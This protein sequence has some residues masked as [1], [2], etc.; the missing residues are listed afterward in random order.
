[1]IVGLAKNDSRIKVYIDQVLNGEFLVENNQSGTASFAYQPF[2]PLSGGNHLVYTEAVDSR[3]KVSSWSN[4]VYFQVSGLIEPTISDQAAIEKSDTVGEI[5]EDTS[6]E[7]LAVTITPIEGTVEEVD[8]L[9]EELNDEEASPVEEEM[10]EAEPTREED[11]VNELIARVGEGEPGKTGI[12]DESKQSQGRLQLNL[13]IFLVFLI[14][15]IVW[16]FWV[17]RELIKERK[18]LTELE[19][20]AKKE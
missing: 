11:E 6:K 15:V 10:I 8:V 13:I 3:G 17:N 7:D 9:G 16:I 14:A 5:Q 19:D 1:L 18:E 2:L 12:L 20:K 4:I